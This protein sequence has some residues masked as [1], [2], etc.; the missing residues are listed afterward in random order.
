MIG[1]FQ[2]NGPCGI[3]VNGNVYNNPYSWSNVSNM[4]YIDQPT[5]V[6]FSYSIPAPGY[7]GSL[8][9]GIIPL[10]NNFCPAHLITCGTYS[11]PDLALTANSTDAAA[12]NFWA[13][14][15]GFMGAFPQYSRNNFNLA[16]E[17]Y[18]GRYGP[19]FSE[20]IET[21]NANNIPNAT[22][23]RLATLLIG[24]GFYDGDVQSNTNFDDPSVNTYD[25]NLN[26]SNRDVYD[27]RE[28]YPDPFP[29]QYYISY[30][31][32]PSVQSAIGAYQN[33]TEVSSTITFGEDNVDAVGDMKKLLERGVNVLMYHG[34]ADLICNWVG[35]EMVSNL[36]NAT[37]FSEAGYVNISTS[38]QVVRGQVKQ[39]GRF[40]FVRVYESGH[41]VPFYQPLLA[42]AMFERA[43]NGKDIATG[44]VNITDDYKTVGTVKSTYRQGNATVQFELT[45]GTSIY[46]T[47]LGIPEPGI[48]GNPGAVADSGRSVT[49]GSSIHRACILLVTWALIFSI[50]IISL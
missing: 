36:I 40:G 10:S 20:Y 28:L 18:G 37:G 15:Q 50:S 27:I 30:L 4:L 45:N 42:L 43:I 11:Y 24:N 1:L 31:N 14:L 13:T 21:Q 39:S 41:E 44:L 33:Y 5:Q 22:N 7:L 12:P 49:S 29:Y 38:D 48:E 46:N 23:I 32:T 2:E 16:A 19:V 34:D 17:S 35:G 6:G 9:G 25:I 8:S 47:D 3:D 26:V